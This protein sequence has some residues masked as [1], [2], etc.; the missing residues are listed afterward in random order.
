MGNHEAMFLDFL[1]DPHSA[2]AGAFIY[3]GGSSTLASYADEYGDVDIPPP[4]V[5]FLQEL[6]L[7]W[8][9]DHTFFVHAGLPEKPIEEIDPVVDGPAMLWIRRKFL[10][11]DYRWSK[12]VVHGHTPVHSVTIRPNRINIDTGCV[13]RR[14][15]SAIALPGER[16]FSVPRQ[17][18]ARRVFLRDVRSRRAAIRFTGAVP[19]QVR[20]RGAVEPFETVDYSELGMYLRDL[21]ERDAMLLAEGDR[22]EGAIGPDAESL[23]QFTGLVVR[24]RRDERGDHYGVR[25]VSSGPSP[26]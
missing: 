23:I 12:L 10:D 15:L 14:R 6:R 20:H 7:Y 22:I 13:F 1:D 19:V 4:H 18:R 25:I 2:R 26:A 9:T 24:C 16:V 21:T 3:N 8:Q 5:A 17:K 11:S